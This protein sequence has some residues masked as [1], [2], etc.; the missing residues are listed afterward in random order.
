MKFGPVPPRR[1]R[2]RHRGPHHPPGRA[3]AE[4][5]HAD[6]PGRGRGAGGGRHQGRRGGAARAGRRVRGQGRG[7]DRRGCGRR[8]ACTSTAP[9]PA[10]PICSPKRPACWWSTRTAI[11]R[12]NRVD[13]A[14]TLATL[15]AYKPVVA[16]EM[17][18]TV[19]I[20]PFASPARRS[21]RR[22]R[23]A[24]KPL[25]PRRALPITK[26]G[27]VSTL[28]PGLATKVVEK[29]L[30]VTEDALAPA[31]ASIVAE[32][33]VPHEQGALAKALDEVLKRGRRTGRGVRRLGHRR[34]A[35]RDPGGGRG[36]RR[37]ASSISACR[38]IPAI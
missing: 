34:P 23:R 13:E 10:A 1:G 17:I 8:R 16:G 5:G 14:I 22:W 30:R 15:P 29:T 33:R 4:E 26:V 31:G 32:R 27:V 19:K 11:D 28:L 37:H 2:R 18:A 12:L 21:T 25:D 9:S 24:G 36:G 38:S 35:R 20:I 6:R 3:G 7:R